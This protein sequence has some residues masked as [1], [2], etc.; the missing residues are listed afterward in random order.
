MRTVN[1]DWSSKRCEFV[2]D[3]ANVGLKYTARF[4][5]NQA[6]AGLTPKTC[7]GGFSSIFVSNTADENGSGR[8]RRT[9][10]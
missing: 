8:Q 9:I 3:L 1:R 7:P 10:D 5:T 6:F 2:I 4:R